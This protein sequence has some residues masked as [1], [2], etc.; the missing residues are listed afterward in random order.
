[1]SNV[2]QRVCLQYTSSQ[3]YIFTQMLIF[4][5]FAVII[6]NYAA[7][8]F[9]GCT[10]FTH[11]NGVLHSGTSYQLEKYWHVSCSFAYVMLA[12]TCQ[13]AWAYQSQ[14]HDCWE[15]GREMNQGISSNVT[16]I[17]ILEYPWISFSRVKKDTD[18]ICFN[19]MCMLHPGYWQVKCWD[20]GIRI[21]WCHIFWP[22]AITYLSTIH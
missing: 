4:N 17:V 9:W 13:F 8:I 16:D 10:Y 21:E 5:T 1:M 11:A 18:E 3:I 20:Y 15:H 14:S 6:R 12:I 22:L 7:V 19:Q 2:D